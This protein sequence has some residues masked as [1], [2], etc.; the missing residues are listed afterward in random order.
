MDIKTPIV[1][2]RG[3]MAADLRD[4]VFNFLGLTKSKSVP[5]YSKRAVT[6]FRDF[7]EHSILQRRMKIFNPHGPRSWWLPYVRH[8]FL[9]S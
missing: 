3:L 6:V 1:A 4:K 7:A 5:G 9:G 2:A 8:T